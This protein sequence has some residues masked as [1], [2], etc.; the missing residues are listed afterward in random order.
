M[1]IDED[2]SV[3]CVTDSVADIGQVSREI[4]Q[5]CRIDRHFISDRT[6]DNDA[7]FLMGQTIKSPFCR[8]PI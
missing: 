7:K 6:S 1:V 8:S 5:P 3:D 2:G 4:V